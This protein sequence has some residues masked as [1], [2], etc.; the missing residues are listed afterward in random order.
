[1]S[2]KHLTAVTGLLLVSAGTFSQAQQPSHGAIN[3]HGSIVEPS[4]N[5]FSQGESLMQLTG[6]P[7]ASRGNLI[8]ARSVQ[9][10]GSVKALQG[11]AADIRLVADSGMSERYYNQSYQLMDTAGRPVRSGSYVVTITSP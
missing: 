6:C 11:S 8:S 9:P 4:C 7:T 1:M 5:A 3:F 10:V 2:V